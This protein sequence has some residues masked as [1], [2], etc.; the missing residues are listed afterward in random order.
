[1]TII[2]DDTE[3]AFSA[4]QFSVKEDGT[5]VAAVT[6]TRTGNLAGIV[7]ATIILSDDTATSPTDYNSSP[8]EV[9]FA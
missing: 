6:I 2:D 8:I 5:P 7:G 4:T 1:L 3:L 9:S